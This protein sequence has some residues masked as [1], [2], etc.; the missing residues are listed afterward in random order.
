MW[1]VCGEGGARVP[2]SELQLQVPERFQRGVESAAAWRIITSLS[3]LLLPLLLPRIG[4]PKPSQKR[5]KSTH[6]RRCRHCCCHCCRPGF[7]TR[8]RRKCI[9]NPRVYVAVAIV[10]AI[11]VAPDL[12]P[13]AVAKALQ[14]HA[15]TALPPLLLP[16]LLRPKIRRRSITNPR[17]YGAVAI[18][19]APDLR[20]RPSASDP[21]PQTHQ[22]QTLNLRP[23]ASDPQPQTLSYKPSASDPEPQTFSLRPSASDPQPQ[24]LHLRPSA[25][26]PQPL[27]LSLRPSTSYPQP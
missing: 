9:T 11:V 21:Q 8:N 18:V 17:V 12:R 1:G 24:T 26:D 25:S 10:V 3:P 20:P 4:V 19:V 7:A 22:P 23:S 14:I 16:L 6:L 2:S 15:F 27:T 5:Y 13:E